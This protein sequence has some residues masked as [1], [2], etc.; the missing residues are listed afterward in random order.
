MGKKNIFL[1]LCITTIAFVNAQEQINLEQ[2]I[3]LTIANNPQIKQAEASRLASTASI[4]KA[5]ANY[6]PQLTANSG[7][8][9]LDPTGYV[10]F[11]TAQGIQDFA[12]IPIDNYN[13]N[14]ELNINIYDF[15]RTNTGVKLAENGEETA[16]V[17]LLRTKQE[18]AFA[19]IQIY[20]QI[21]F[22]QEAIKVQNKQIEA[23]NITLTQTKKLQE[24]G[25][26]TNY[27]IM[28]TEVKVS[29]ASDRLLDLQTD[30]SNAFIQ[31][32]QLTGQE[33]IDTEKLVNNWLKIESP[34]ALTTN[35][36]ITNR[37]E[38]KLSE[39]QTENATL[40]ELLA[41]RNF[42]PYLS[43]NLQGGYKNAIQPD[44]N[45]LQLNYVAT[46]Q[47]TIPLFN[48]FKNKA[49][50]KEAKALKDASDFN[51]ENTSNQ[52]EAEVKQAI[53]NLNNSYQKIERSN[54]QVT[55]AEQAAELARL[56]YKN[57]VIT[58]LDLLDAEI[59]L[60][61]SEINKLNTIFNYTLNTY[62][63]RKAMGINLY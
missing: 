5:K 36:N 17:S 32:I 57:G 8:T 26:A 60:S 45:L 19:T 12:F 31:L 37:P 56:K 1:L 39:L 38:F 6:Y 41:R 21:H 15:G 47:L 43:A 4:E 14:L 33:N 63:L 55:Q 52:L 2:A 27:E 40:Q 16:D 11:P 18:L 42:N 24:N 20:Y 34:N 48:G 30:L 13:L 29:S 61:Q 23:F 3:A 28:T 62:R 59:A 22:L 53:E 54:L 25:E 51:L 50:L 49:S 7:Y 58:N 35:I 9:R 10:P 44:I 46:A